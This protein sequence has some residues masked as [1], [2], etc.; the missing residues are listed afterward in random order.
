MD[1]YPFRAMNSEIVLAAEGEPDAIAL[2]FEQTRIFVEA[3]EARFTRFAETS[4]LSQ[5]NRSAGT[6]FR[7]STVTTD[8]AAFSMAAAISS[9]YA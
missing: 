5:L 4:E 3:S 1:Y 7:A 6:W 2:G 8:F 9:E